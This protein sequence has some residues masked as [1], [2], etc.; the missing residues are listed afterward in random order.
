VF[1]WI[2]VIFFMDSFDLT[3]CTFFI[4]HEWRNKFPIVIWSY[5]GNIWLLTI[6][7]H[8]KWPVILPYIMSL[9]KLSYSP[10][11]RVNAIF[12]CHILSRSEFE[13]TEM[14]TEFLVGHTYFF[15]CCLLTRLTSYSFVILF[16]E[17]VSTW[18][19]Y[20]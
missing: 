20:I 1:H 16:M 19:G 4:L 6:Y 12:W 7:W 13:V 11:V 14:H 9:P 17:K 2:N 18:R 15:V 5:F 3:N 10:H 8:Y